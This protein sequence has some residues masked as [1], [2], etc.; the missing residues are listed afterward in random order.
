RRGQR[1]SGCDLDRRTVGQ[2]GGA[3]RVAEAARRA[4][5]DQKGPPADH[6]IWHSRR[7]QAGDGAL[8]KPLLFRGGVWGGAAAWRARAATTPLRLGS[9]LP[10][11]APP[12]LKRR[13]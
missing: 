7:V 1:E 5:G 12:P 8:T 9:K 10:S 2:Q 3:R 4:G 13:G 6:R 11:L